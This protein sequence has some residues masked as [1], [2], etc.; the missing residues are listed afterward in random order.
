MSEI[1][2]AE[3]SVVDIMIK[4]VTAH[5]GHLAPY[6]DQIAV[7]FREKASKVGGCI[8]LGKHKK[9]PLLVN[10]LGDVD[11]TFIIELAADEWHSLNT[12]QR[13]ALI[14]HHLC[15]CRVDIN[16]KTGDPKFYIA[17]PDY[18]GYRGEIER[19][20]LW[21]PE[22]EGAEEDGPNPVLEAFGVQKGDA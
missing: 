7:I 12:M 10:I 5:H 17:P 4:Y 15:G 13:E 21:R 8:V 11:Y 19:H 20:G 18:V 1:W 2:K 22:P 14:D 16:P 6:V 9:A 3:Q